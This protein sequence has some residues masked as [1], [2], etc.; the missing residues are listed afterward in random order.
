MAHFLVSVVGLYEFTGAHGLQ[1]SPMVIVWLAIAWLPYQ[2]VICY[3]AVRAVRRQM[4][5][6]NN[7][8]KT[9][10]IGAHRGELYDGA[11]AHDH[12]A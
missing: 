11:V 3:S 5:G 7:W 1:A 2:L 6:V 8:E 12:A 4:L 9:Q 10:H